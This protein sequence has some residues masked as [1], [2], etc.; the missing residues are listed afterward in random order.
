MYSIIISINAIIMEPIFT[1]PASG[2]TVTLELQ[3]QID[4]ATCA[5][6]PAHILAPTECEFVVS[7]EAALARV[8]DWAFTRGFAL[9]I[10][11]S[12]PY[13]VVY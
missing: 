5:L 6:P 4:A 2:S 13:R 12:K 10:E 9:A 11:S 3:A 8:Q 1:S 7:K